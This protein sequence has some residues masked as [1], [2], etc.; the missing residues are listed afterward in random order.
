MGSMIHLK[1]R[2]KSLNI[3]KL[4]TLTAFWSAT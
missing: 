3:E 1:E 2:G 4:I